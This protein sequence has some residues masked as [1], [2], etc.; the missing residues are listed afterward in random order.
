MEFLGSTERTS[1][2]KYQS[3]AGLSK[4]GLLPVIAKNILFYPIYKRIVL[5][6]Y[7][8]TRINLN[9]ITERINR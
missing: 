6:E 3:S 5:T 8:C 2:E 9:V 1:F 7:K 4:K